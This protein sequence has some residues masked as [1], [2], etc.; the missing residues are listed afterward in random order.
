MGYL[1]E[2]KNGVK[3]PKLHEKRKGTAKNINLNFGNALPT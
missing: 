1:N 2:V 3:N